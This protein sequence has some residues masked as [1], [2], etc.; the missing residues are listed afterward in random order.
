MSVTP[1][2]PVRSGEFEGPLDLLLELV[3]RNQVSLE[4]LPIAKI[5]SQYLEY[6]RAAQRANVDLGADFIY[7]SATLIQIKSR[8]LLPQDPAL[9]R[10]PDAGDSAEALIARLREHAQAKAAAEMLKT[11]LE[12]EETVWTHTGF[13]P[14]LAFADEATGASRQPTLADLIDTLGEALRRVRNHTVVAV[15]QDAVT[16]E[17][18]IA[19][20]RSEIAAKPRPLRITELFGQ[21]PSQV[22][23]CCLFLGILEMGRDGHVR[24]EQTEP[25]GEVTVARC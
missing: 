4:S 18:R 14:G 24:I 15:E 7:M 21:Q 5:I 12:V 13:E 11:K 6:I 22:A 19:W 9:R 10:G 20:L 23:R 3:R 16:I 17:D 1:I 2:I 8:L 25:F